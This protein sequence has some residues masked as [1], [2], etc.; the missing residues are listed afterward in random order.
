MYVKS[1]FLF[2]NRFKVGF[3]WPATIIVKILSNINSEIH[4]HVKKKD[5]IQRKIKSNA[6]K[7]NV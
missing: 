1:V 2:L 5:T 6:L 3:H 7:L 4:K